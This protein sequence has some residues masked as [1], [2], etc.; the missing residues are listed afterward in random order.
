MAQLLQSQGG[1]DVDRRP[2]VQRQRQIMG[3]A[4][5]LSAQQIGDSAAARDVGL[6]D[7][8]R[9]GIDPRSKYTAS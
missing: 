2:A 3:A 4:D 1:M 6:Q 5:R 9:A 8:D 7:I